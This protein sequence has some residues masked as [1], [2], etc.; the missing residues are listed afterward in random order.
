MLIIFDLDDT[1]V[2]TSGCLTHHRLQKALHAM[3]MEGLQIGDGEEALQ[4]LRR[5]DN[6]SESARSALSEFLEILGADR[7]FLEV[8]IE[9]V[10][11]D[12][13]VDIELFPLEGAVEVLFELSISHEL[14]LV[15]NGKKEVQ[16]EKLKKAGIDSRIFSKI[17]VSEEKSKKA[18]YRAIVEELGY[19]PSGVVV[20]GDRIA[21]DLR[22]ARELG[23]KTVQ[24]RW[25]RGLSS[26]GA[27]GDVDYTIHSLKEIKAI[28]ANLAGFSKF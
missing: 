21:I 26:T 18:R 15:S 25:G 16:S 6:S 3:Q 1:L 19:S 10:Y 24:M 23:Y 27:K 20:C 2:D 5:I 4:Q 7:R 13:P 28:V 12:A 22:P 17:A 11:G 9:E 8:G 14:A